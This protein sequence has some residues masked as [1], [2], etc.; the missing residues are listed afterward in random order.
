MK[1]DQ[2]AAHHKDTNARKVENAITHVFH[3][4]IKQEEVR[5]KSAKKAAS[6]AT[7]SINLEAAQ[8]KESEVESQFI[9]S[10]ASVVNQ[11]KVDQAE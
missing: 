1:I 10:L 3:E 2:Y 7:L 6:V 5:T 4:A 11:V 8:K 9:A